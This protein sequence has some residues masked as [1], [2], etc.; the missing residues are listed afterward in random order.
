M[1][2]K[3]SNLMPRGPL[4]HSFHIFFKREP[5]SKEKTYG[6][7]KIKSIVIAKLWILLSDVGNA[8]VLF[9]IIRYIQEVFCGSF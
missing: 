1:K 9:V 3:S 4:D 5:V 7:M 8:F 6:I 2:A